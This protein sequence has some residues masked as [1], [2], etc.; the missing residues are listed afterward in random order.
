M[1]TT[2]SVLNHRKSSNLSNGKK[3]RDCAIKVYNV[4]NNFAAT[5]IA[6]TSKVDM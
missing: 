1:G 4:G 5:F 2:K 6:L 3:E